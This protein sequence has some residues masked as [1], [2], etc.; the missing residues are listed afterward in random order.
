MHDV[1]RETEISSFIPHYEALSKMPI[2][3]A[4]IR[5]DF[6]HTGATYRIIVRLNLSFPA[7]D[8]RSVPPFIIRE[9]NVIISSKQLF[10][11]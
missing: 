4:S 11:H 9:E 6:P 7:I 10:M 2:V 1:G 3:N 8:H 5:Y